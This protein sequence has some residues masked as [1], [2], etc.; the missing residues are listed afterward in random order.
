MPHGTPP[1]LEEWRLKGV[2]E[3]G[4]LDSVPEERFDRVVKLAALLLDAPMAV[5]SLVDR[6]RQ[7]FKA[8][9][10]LQVQ[11][12]ARDVSFCDHTISAAD[13]RMVIPD[14]TLDARFHDNLLVLGPPHIRAYAGV[15]VTDSLGRRLGTLCVLDTRVRTFTPATLAGLE[16]LAGV[17][18]SELR[19]VAQNAY[20]S[21][22]ERYQK[23]EDS[24]I[25][26]FR[27]SDQFMAVANNEGYLERANPALCHALDYTPEELGAAPWA[28]FIHPDD[29]EK[30]LAIVREMN[31]SQ[32]VGVHT[33]RI[34]HKRGHYVW[35][36]ISGAAA[37]DGSKLFLVGRNYTQEKELTDGIQSANNM[38][39]A[40]NDSLSQFVADRTSR[41]PFEILL[42]SL[43]HVSESAYGFVGEVLS[44]ASGA[45]FLRSHAL[46]NIAWNEETRLHYA[47][48]VNEGLEFRNLDTLFGRVMTSGEAL[49]ANSAATDKRRGGLPN[50]HPSLDTFLGI[51]IYSGGVMVGMVGLANRNEGYDEKVIARLDLL[52]STAGNLI[53]AYRAE[54]S[55]QAAERALAHSETL[56]RITLN[57]IADG[58]ATIGENGSIQSG[59]RALKAMFG[60][61]SDDITNKTLYDLIDV[62]ESL[63][64]LAKQHATRSTAAGEKAERV[65]T[66]ALH[67]SGHYFD[68]EVSLS[69][70]KMQNELR[71]VAVFR[72]VTEWKKTESDLR[73][74]KAQADAANQAK[75]LF[76]ASMSHEF[77]TPLNGIVGMS[78]LAIDLATMEEQR[79]YLDTVI[80]SARTL[81]RLIND[82]LDYSKIEASKLTL[83]HI[84]FNPSLILQNIIDHGI[85][86]SQ[87]KGIDLVIKIDEKLPELVVGDPT[88]VRQVLLNLIDNA[89]KYTDR[90]SIQVN[91]RQVRRRTNGRVT[92]Q[93]A[94]KDT[95][96][97]IAAERKSLIFEAF[98]QAD[99]SDTRM[100]GGT[101][102]GLTIC[103]SLLHLMN[104]KM[105]LQSAPGVGST[106]AFDLELPVATGKREHVAEAGSA[107][108]PAQ[109]ESTSAETALRPLVILLAEDNPV[110]QKVATTILT[111]RGHTVVLAEDGSKAVR[112][113]AEQRFDIILMDI[114]MPVID[115]VEATIQIRAKEGGSRSRVPI[116]ALTAHALQGDKSRF[117]EAGMDG[118]LSKPFQVSELLATL[119]S[120]A[121]QSPSA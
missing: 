49:I 63:P 121:S 34:R 20:L 52:L 60:L 19:A 116:L 87:K 97:G 67:S 2:Y 4:M 10:G 54:G 44:D 75:S 57:S 11:Q 16:D 47:A 65:Q 88:R 24:V 3:S 114:Q 66:R 36:H 41:N 74:A 12:T 17:I 42:D 69:S 15:M 72:D 1:E 110:N 112:L 78:T 8:R 31:A 81:T 38:L 71:Y 84:E 85:L 120:V 76:L 39:R 30:T 18:E 101:G 61:S 108:L 117:L 58:V 64:A 107:E 92:I 27:L 13:G 23:A 35:V 115:G 103:A 96:R 95:G 79:S 102:L 106:F 94:V 113:A 9:I 33:T 46:T 50:G 55:K 40:I 56:Q 59:N 91:V 89:I 53:M 118:Y 90:G 28:D 109:I 32:Q 26:L 111:S 93:F 80:E 25:Q 82:V 43:L 51:P 119:T 104:S 100:Y 29:L 70:M 21:S 14:A 99:S 77:R 86:R 6:E 45:P 73:A 22:I 98:A 68:V 37:A 5:F 62:E 83:E 105:Q 48:S 7:W